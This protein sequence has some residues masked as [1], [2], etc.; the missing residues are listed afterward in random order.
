MSRPERFVWLTTQA[1]A[2]TPL[3]S[4]MARLW[5]EWRFSYSRRG[6]LTYKLPTD[7]LIAEDFE[8][9]AVLARAY[10]FSLGRVAVGDRAAALAE[11]W[12]LAAGHTVEALHVFERD[13]FTPG[14][15]HYEPGPTDDAAQLRHELID[16]AG[17]QG[18]ALAEIA[19]PG[20]GVMSC[21]MVEPGEWWIGFHRAFAWATCRAGGFFDEPLPGEAVSRA[22]LKMSESLAWSGLPIKAG[23][24]AAEIGCAPGGS[25]QA[26]LAR[27]LRVLGID[28]AEVDPRV[29]AQPGFTWIRKR[30]HEVRVRDFRR[31][32]WLT[33]DLNVAPA[34]TLETVERIVTHP[35]SWVRGL[36]LT[37]KLPDW[38]LTDEIPGWLNRVR[39]WGYPD[40]RARHL[41]H[42]RQ[43]ICVAAQ[44]LP[45]PRTAHRR[46]VSGE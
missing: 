33:A 45:R 23:E 3:K 24:L 8:L 20:Q 2:E 43:E 46:R 30:G 42:N 44:G 1:G 36:L 12:R 11:V 13:R 38:K 31:V 41:H 15:R 19:R 14:W 7:L 21:L 26:L 4:E 25:S 28:P 37:L 10:A 29:T 6:F 27:G 35:E 18:A 39:S 16:A 5:P 32:R 17:A 9:G 34:Y 40:V 22:Y